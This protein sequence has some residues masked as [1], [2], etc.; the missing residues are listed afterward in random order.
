[1]KQQH[2]PIAGQTWPERILDWM[3]REENFVWSMVGT[4]VYAALLIIGSYISANVLK[5]ADAANAF[6]KVW[7]AFFPIIAAIALLNP[8]SAAWGVYMEKKLRKSIGDYLAAYNRCVYDELV[9]YCM[10]IKIRLGI[11][12]A[13][14]KMLQC[15]ELVWNDGCYRLPTDE[16][17]RKWRDQWLTEHGVKISFEELRTM[18]AGDLKAPGESIE[19]EFSVGEHDGLR[20]GKAEG[21][22]PGATIF[23]LLPGTGKRCDFTTFQEA[24]GAAVFNGENLEAVWADVILTSI[25]GE[26]PCLIGTSF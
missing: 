7:L 24:V 20:M 15:H 23:W 5:R 1:M 21:G 25:N 17:R 26:C 6:L 10:P 8:L 3:T 18:F 19:V 11:D 4:A 14:E 12:S 16:D 13:I 9:A 2:R 22:A